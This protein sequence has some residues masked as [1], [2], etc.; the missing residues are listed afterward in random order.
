[1]PDVAFIRGA[2]VTLYGRFYEETS[3]GSSVLTDPDRKSV[4]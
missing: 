2:V 4:V 3:Y 1:M